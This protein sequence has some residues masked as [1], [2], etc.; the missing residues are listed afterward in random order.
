MAQHTR[1]ADKIATAVDPMPWMIRS[2]Q[3]PAQ[4]T[5]A[6]STEQALDCDV[7]VIG[8][9]FVASMAAL[10]LR[11]R[12]L[13]VTCL[14]T[15]TAEQPLKAVV[16]EALTEGT[17]VFLRHELEL[18]DWLHANAYRKFGFDFVTQ[19]RN[20]PAPRVLDECHELLLSLTPIEKIPGAF[21][22]LIPTF[23]V[24]RPLLD[25]EVRRRAAAAGAEYRFEAAVEHVELGSGDQPVHRVMY[26]ERNAEARG[27][28]RCRFVLDAS[29]RRRVLGKQLGICRPMEGLETASIWNRFTKVRNDGEFWKTFHGIDR[30]RHTIHWTGAGFWFWWIHIDENTTSVGVSFDKNQHQPNVKSDDRGFWEMANKFPALLEALAG[31]EPVEPFSYYAHLAHRSEH[32]VSATGYALIGDSSAFADALYSVGIEMS[33]RQLVAV[34]P[35]VEAACAGER[36]CEKTVAKLNQEHEL[37]Q[38]S[39]R[40]LNKFKYEH[41]WHQPHVLM[42]TA[43]YELA[44]IAALY[45]LQDRKHWTRENLDRHYRLQWGCVHRRRRLVEFMTEAAKDGPRELDEPRLLAKALLPGRVIYT[46]TWPLWKL[47]KALPYFF[48]LTRT[49]GYMERLAQRWRVWPD[50]LTFMAGRRKRELPPLPSEREGGGAVEPEHA[51]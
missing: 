14:E 41:A 50:F 32:W 12:G 49:W 24:N 18:G 5:A 39:I 23:H 2:A 37:L 4:M 36:P 44:E 11:K 8:G 27:E 45:H 42:Q 35:L 16:G 17:S 7:A 10:M 38:D 31:A 9:G 28:L 6:R 13:R 30:R 47:P 33:C 3:M 20:R 29:G 15:R 26:A 48:I 34:T 43:L 46:V 40:L 21:D 1:S 19:P 25:A 51:V 22:N